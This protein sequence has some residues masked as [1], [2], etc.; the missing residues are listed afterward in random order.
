MPL[1]PAERRLYGAAGGH[2]SWANTSD[3]TA[4]TAPARAGQRAAEAR[5]IDPDGTMDQAELERRID[6]AIKARMAVLAARSVRSRA[7]VKAART[8]KLSSTDPN[9]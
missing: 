5:R 4:R 9:D 8:A 3:R 7:R 2:K 1:T 6:S